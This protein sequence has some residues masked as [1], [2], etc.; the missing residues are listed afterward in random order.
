MGCGWGGGAK[1]FTV[2]TLGSVESGKGET[3]F[4]LVIR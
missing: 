1:G 4:Q 3:G 2:V